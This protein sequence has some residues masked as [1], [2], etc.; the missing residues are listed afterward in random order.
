MARYCAG[1]TELR[2]QSNSIR[3]TDS[4]EAVWPW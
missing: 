1:A 2:R 4:S 3:R